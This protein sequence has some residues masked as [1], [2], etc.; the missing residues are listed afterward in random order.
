MESLKN[1]DVKELLPQQPP[2]VMIDNI[3]YFDET[4][5][6]TGFLIKNDN[7]FVDNNYFAEAGIIENI[8]QTAAARLGYI[9]KYIQNDKIKLGFIGEIKNLAI[10]RFP[11]VNDLITTSIEVKNEVFSTLIVYAEVKIN[12]ELIAFGDMKISTTDLT[13]QN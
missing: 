3:L 12:D 6:T 11:K 4:K 13:S 2:F 8:A 10:E 9:N 7:I 1:I 5:I